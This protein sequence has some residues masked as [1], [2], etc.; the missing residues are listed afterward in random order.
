M[1]PLGSHAAW[2][3]GGMITTTLIGILP[4]HV[5]EIQAA[6]TIFVHPRD[7]CNVAWEYS[8]D[9]YSGWMTTSYS[10]ETRHGYK[11]TTV[12]VRICYSWV[13]LNQKDEGTHFWSSHSRLSSGHTLRVLSQREIQWKWNACYERSGGGEIYRSHWK[14]INSRCKSPMQRYTR[15]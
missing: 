13:K 11:G 10:N 3:V 2:T 15:L 1:A 6:S 14:T 8:Y 12:T 4:I 9:R 5:I 7:W